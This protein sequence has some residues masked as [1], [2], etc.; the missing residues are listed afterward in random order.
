[1][2]ILGTLSENALLGLSARANE[3][4][5]HPVVLVCHPLTLISVNIRGTFSKDLVTIQSPFSEHSV[6]LDSW[7]ILLTQMCRFPIL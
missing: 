4:V 3:P 7:V 5:P 1:M 6:N 2:N